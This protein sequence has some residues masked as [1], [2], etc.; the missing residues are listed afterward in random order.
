MI[1]C[2]KYYHRPYRYRFVLIIYLMNTI[3]IDPFK[4][5]YLTIANVAYLFI[6]VLKVGD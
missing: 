2:I 1:L 4:Y 6:Y 3:F 5:I